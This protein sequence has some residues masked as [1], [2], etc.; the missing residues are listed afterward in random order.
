MNPRLLAGLLLIGV[1]IVSA[2]GQADGE[3]G[4]ALGAPSGDATATGSLP[5]PTAVLIT[6]TV[7]ASPTVDIGIDIDPDQMV[8]AAIEYSEWREAIVSGTPDALLAVPGTPES[9]RQLGLNI[10]NWNPTC[11]RP[12]YLVI[13]KGDFDGS[14]LFAVPTDERE[15][16]GRY[17]AYV[18]D[19]TAGVPGEVTF[20]VLSEDG[21]AFKQALDD[22]TLPD[23]DFTVPESS[24]PYPPCEDVTLPGNPGPEPTGAP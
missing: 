1:S 8:A 19:L 11:A 12:M 2:C 18:F 5:E 10:G 24:P 13:L 14:N 20:T 21:A 9:I 3:Q 17:V 16:P 15:L 4:I 6:P 23:P 22:P 7:Q